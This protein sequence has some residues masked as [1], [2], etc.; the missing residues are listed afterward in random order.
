MIRNFEPPNWTE[1]ERPGHFQWGAAC[2]AGLIA[3]LILLIIPRG[4]PWAELTFFAPVVMGRIVSPEFGSSFV[5]TVVIHLAVSLVCGLVISRIVAAVTQL[6]ALI[7]GGI[8]GLAI[9]LANYVIVSWWIPELGGNEMSVMFTHIV[10]GLIAGGAYRGLLRR[11]PTT[12]PM[13]A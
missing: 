12:A 7:V 13:T 6:R 1:P 3:G 2:G 9:Y 11:T 8:A 4:S 10:F 5:S